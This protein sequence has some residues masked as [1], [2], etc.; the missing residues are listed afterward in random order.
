[1]Q[2]AGSCRPASLDDLE[3]AAPSRRSRRRGAEPSRRNR[4]YE[5]AEAGALLHIDASQLPKF[6]RPGPLGARRPLASSIRTR[7]AGKIEVDRSSSTTTRR[8]A[9]CELHAA[10]NARERLGARSA[11]R[12]LVCANRAAGRSRR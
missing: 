1:M 2:L 9:Y 7:K 8:L 6:E 10:E 11:R 4:R 5:W 12:C 3:G